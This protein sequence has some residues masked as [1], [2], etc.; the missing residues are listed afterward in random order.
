MVETVPPAMVGVRTG[1]V[2]GL[3]VVDIDKHGTT[4]GFQSLKDFPD[5]DPKQTATS[6][7]AGGGQHQYYAYPGALKSTVLAP[8]IDLLAD[9]RMVVAPSSVRADGKPYL[10]VN[11]R[12]L[13]SLAP[14]P[15]S[16]LNRLKR[17]PA[18]EAR[19]LANKI[20]AAVEGERHILVRDGTFALAHEVVAGRLLESEFRQR[21]ADMAAICVPPLDKLHVDDLIQSALTKVRLECGS[22]KGA[23]AAT[24]EGPKLA[25]RNP[26]RK[27]STAPH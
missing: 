2:N 17:S 9:N 8:G 5:L 15:T 24:V 1:K 26:G 6:L 27:R 19:R 21:I 10:L 22:R 16:V 25:D 14:L 4:D 23:S 11:G 18:E 3:T 12:D 20:G 13:T 7:T